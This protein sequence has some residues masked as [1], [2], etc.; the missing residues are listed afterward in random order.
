VGKACKEVAWGVGLPVAARLARLEASFQDLAAD[1]VGKAP[2]G[3]VIQQKVLATHM[4][5]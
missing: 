3:E 5:A 1:V 4:C 2:S